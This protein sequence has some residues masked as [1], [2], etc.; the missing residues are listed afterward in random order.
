MSLLSRWQKEPALSLLSDLKNAKGRLSNTNVM[1]EALLNSVYPW[2]WILFIF[3][4]QL[5]VYNQ[6]WENRDLVLEVVFCE[7]PIL[8]IKTFGGVSTKVIVLSCAIFVVVVLQL[9][10]H[11]RKLVKKKS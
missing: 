4:H 9:A 7:I 6:K 11:W 3:T 5:T 10:Q 1:D 8:I 2:K